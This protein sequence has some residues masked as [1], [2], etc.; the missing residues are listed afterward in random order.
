MTAIHPDANLGY[1]HL[2]VA[3]LARSLAFYQ[4]NLGFKLHRRDGQTAYLGA[5]GPDLLLLT[6]QPGARQISGVTGL[7]H[8]AILTPSRLALAQSLRRLAETRTPVQGFSDHGVSEAIY[9][10][11][12]DGNGIE[13]Y[14]DR[15]RS[16]WP[17]AN[18][19]LAM[20]TDPL[21]VEGIL[22]E[23]GSQPE[24]WTG[25]SPQTTLG[26]IHLH[27]ARIKEAETFYCDVLGF[28]LMQRF[29][30]SA[31]FISA[32]GYHHHI[33]AN[34]WA[35]L[36]A[37]PPPPDAAGLRYFTINL[38][39]ETALAE[40]VERI[41]QAGLTFQHRDQIVFLRDPSRN[42]VVLSAG[43]SPEAIAGVV[44]IGS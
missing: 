26:H 24:P 2:T 16:E 9:L 10:A 30:Y 34:I 8:F 17:W 7:Y 20:V 25:L 40:V 23:L 43:Q 5:G 32:G 19:Q 12:P 3:N 44:S 13:I 6:E 29:G 28:D 37:P 21:D 11:D 14:R 42:G 22:A 36:N 33:G 31:S 27:V 41:E 4:E 35:G 1:V 18:G 15:P 39:T 38:P